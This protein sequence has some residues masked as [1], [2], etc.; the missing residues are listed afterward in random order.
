MVQMRRVI[1]VGSMESGRS[2]YAVCCH[3]IFCCVILLMSIKYKVHCTALCSQRAW[4]INMVYQVVHD[5]EVPTVDTPTCMT[6][7]QHKLNALL[8]GI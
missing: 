4:P 1:G 8:P 2:V 6:L 7:F 3:V 5:P